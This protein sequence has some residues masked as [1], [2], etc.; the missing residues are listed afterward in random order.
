M[1]KNNQLPLLIGFWT[2]QAKILPAGRHRIGSAGDGGADSLGPGAFVA[3]GGHPAEHVVGAGGKARPARV[4]RDEV[5]QVRNRPMN[6]ITGKEE[7]M[8]PR[9]RNVPCWVFWCPDA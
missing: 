9:Q 7:K 1:V 3:V 8:P 2:N 5:L 6:T 4:V